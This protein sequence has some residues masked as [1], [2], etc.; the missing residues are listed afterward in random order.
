MDG[1]RVHA[2]MNTCFLRVT[3]KVRVTLALL[4]NSNRTRAHK[5]SPQRMSSTSGFLC[6]W[7]AP[8]NEMAGSHVTEAVEAK[9]YNLIN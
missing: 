9:D 6:Y 2:H 7:Y 3:Q 4:A 1:V 8:E 5:E